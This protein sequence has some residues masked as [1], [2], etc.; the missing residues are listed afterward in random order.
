VVLFETKDSDLNIYS[1]VHT[2]YFN[3]T[4]WQFRKRGCVF[5]YVSKSK[6]SY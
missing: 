6:I 5:F 4:S 2:M 1:V 3:D